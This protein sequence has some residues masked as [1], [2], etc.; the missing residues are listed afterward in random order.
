MLPSKREVVVQDLRCKFPAA[1]LISSMGGS[2]VLP[3]LGTI[4]DAF[5]NPKQISDNRLPFNSHAMR[6]CAAVKDIQMQ[7]IPLLNS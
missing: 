2:K 4:D 3:A 1:K 7:Y 6:Q 5:V